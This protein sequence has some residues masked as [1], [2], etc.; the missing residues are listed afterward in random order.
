MKGRRIGLR[1]ALAALGL[2]LLDWVS[3]RVFL[4]DG[5]LFGRPVAPFDPP[6]FSNSQRQALARLEE[7]IRKGRVGESRFDADLGWCNHPN[8][9]FGEFRYDWAGARIAADELPRVRTAGVK[10]LVAVGCSMTHGEEV[11]ARESWCARLSAELPNWQVANLGVAAFGVDQALLRLR[12]DGFPLD[13]DEVWL[14][15]LPRAALRITTHYRPLLDHWSL[16]V[17]FKPR[18]RLTSAGSLQLE[19]SP[20]STIDDIPRLLGSQAAFLAALGEDPW[21]A[22]VPWAYAPRGSSWLHSSGAARVLLTVLERTGRAIPPCFDDESD[23]GRLLTAIVQTMARECRS[24]S[25]EFR[26]VVLPGR[27]DLADRRGAG[28]GYWEEWA[29]RRRSE[30]IGVVDLA[31]ALEAGEGDSEKLFAP[32]GHYNAAASMLV[33]R[34]LRAVLER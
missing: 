3:N 34:A 30:G 7:K 32:E 27:D 11:S 23:F 24:R 29:D 13:P 2:L 28:R 22:R 5:K 14:G 10:R 6:I 4:S 25:V 8:T 18:F 12:R 26:V 33:A 19:P 1:L 20:T 9:G 16:D 17:A 31:P 15:V 21:V